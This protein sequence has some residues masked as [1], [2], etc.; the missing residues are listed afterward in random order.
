[1]S[2]ISGQSSHTPYSNWYN[3]GGDSSGSEKR[4][5]DSDSSSEREKSQ[6]EFEEVNLSD[7]EKRACDSDGFSESEKGQNECK[8]VNLSDS[9]KK[10]CDSE[11]EKNQNE[12]KDVNLIDREKREYHSDDS[13]SSSDSD[14]D[15]NERTHQTFANAVKQFVY[16]PSKAS[17]IA[18]SFSPKF[19]TSIKRVA[20]REIM[21]CL[22]KEPKFPKKLRQKHKRQR[23]KYVLGEIELKVMNDAL[24]IPSMFKFLEAIKPYVNG[25]V[26]AGPNFSSQKYPNLYNTLEEK[27]FEIRNEH[28]WSTP[29][30]KTKLMSCTS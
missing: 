4:E 20:L 14:S 30:K 29:P 24:D 1:M 19:I 2:Y 10:A 12:R 5:C 21:D 15:I 13:Y 28:I 18:R 23:H 27:R 16:E 17:Y 8:E 11:G 26:Y 9:E 6:N 22:E 7:S 25:V 3:W